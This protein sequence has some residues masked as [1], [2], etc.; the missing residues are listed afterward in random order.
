M[1]I[2]TLVVMLAVTLL[3]LCSVLVGCPPRKPTPVAQQVDASLASFEAKP[4]R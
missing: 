1:G 4:D 2:R 3:L